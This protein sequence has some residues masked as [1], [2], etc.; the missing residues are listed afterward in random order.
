MVSEEIKTNQGRVAMLTALAIVGGIVGIAGIVVGVV[1]LQKAQTDS[2][3]IV[4]LRR[5]L[6]ISA[7]ALNK[8]SNSLS[9]QETRLTTLEATVKSD[10][11]KLSKMTPQ[12]AAIESCLPEVQSEFNGLEI[13]GTISSPYISN[14]TKTSLACEKLLYRNVR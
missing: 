8:A 1:A 11:A 10:E 13:E 2:T 12:V 9:A 7:P 6:A 4:T 5:K 14:K 3:Q